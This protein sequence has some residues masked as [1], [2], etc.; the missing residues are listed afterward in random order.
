MIK[1]NY[2]QGT[3]DPKKKYKKE[4]TIVV[5]PRFKE[6]FYRNY[7]MYPTTDGSGPGVG[8]SSMT[9]FKSVQDFLK[10]RRKKLKGKYVADPTYINSNGKKSKASLRMVIFKKAIDFALD[11]QVTPIPYESNN[12]GSLIS[13]Q[14]LPFNDFENKSVDNLNHGRDYSDI[15]NSIEKIFDKYLSSPSPLMGMPDGI[16]PESDKDADATKSNGN[17]GYGT[18]DSGN[19]TYESRLNNDY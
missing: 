15:N 10:E 7:D 18:T 11:N 5:E 4:K 16:T 8:M 6:V 9:D 17:P 3:E 13:D 2:Y 19:L 1:N 14:Y 12:Q